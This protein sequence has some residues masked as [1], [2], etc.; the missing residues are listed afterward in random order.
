MTEIF[1]FCLCAISNLLELAFS[2][3]VFCKTDSIPPS[4]VSHKVMGR[5]HCSKSPGKWF[6]PNH[7][8]VAQ[9]ILTELGVMKAETHAEQNVVVVWCKYTSSWM[10]EPVS[11]VLVFL[12][13]AA[14][15][16]AACEWCPLPQQRAAGRQQSV[17]RLWCA[18][19]DKGNLASCMA[20]AGSNRPFSLDL[21]FMALIS[22][23]VWDCSLKC[24]RD[25]LTPWR[26]KP[27]RP[28]TGL[29]QPPQR[30]TRTEA[31]ILCSHCDF[32]I[33]PNVNQS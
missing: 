25:Q 22:G 21:F 31:D 15:G 4:R 12:L 11:S 6:L 28:H 26:R 23:R 30:R 33:T 3:F 19:W 17:W 9:W 24:L 10:F 16:T 14:S 8:Q 20:A 7:L 18:L 32:V 13:L 27:P 2:L 1:W 29:L 5:V